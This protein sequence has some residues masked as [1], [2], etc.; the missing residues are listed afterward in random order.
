MLK[1]EEKKQ[2]DTM[3]K[4]KEETR[5]AEARM[6]EANQGIK[7]GKKGW[8]TERKI[9]AKEKAD[10]TMAKTGAETAK[11]DAEAKV[12][13]IQADMY[14]IKYK[15]GTIERKAI[16]SEEQWFTHW[17]ASEACDEYNAEIGRVSHQLGEDEALERLKVVLAETYP[18]LDWST[19][20]SL[21]QEI[22]DAEADEIHAQIEKE[23]AEAEARLQPAKGEH[24]ET[25]QVAGVPRL[26]LRKCLLD[27]RLLYFSIFLLCNTADESATFIVCDLFNQ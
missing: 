15:L 20:W 16:W 1:D 23:D 8:E 22:Y 21:Y 13:L 19:V 9:W 2:F 24:D 5:L 18:S 11:A 27:L 25:S 3:W 4:V 14:R 26:I 17:K 12:T 7:A 10:L 6:D